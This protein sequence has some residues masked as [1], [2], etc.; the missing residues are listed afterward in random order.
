MT[1]SKFKPFGGLT[2]DKSQKL[3]LFGNEVKESKH[4]PIRY[5]VTPEIF[6]TSN[7]DLGAV[8][9]VSGIPFEVQGASELNHLQSALGFVIQSLGD[10]YAFYVTQ[11][12][13]QQPN[14]L[15]SN[16]PEGFSRDF[17]DAYNS[18]FQQ[19]QLYVNDIFITLLQKAG[20]TKVKKGLSFLEHLNARKDYET[21]NALNEAKLRKFKTALLNLSAA[22]KQYSP[23]ILGEK[24]YEDGLPEAE[25]LGFLSILVNGETREYTFPNQNIAEFVPEKRL[26]FGNNTLH[27]Q[28]ATQGDDL[29]GAMLSVKTYAPYT[30]PGLLDEMINMPFSYISTHSFLGIDKN[31]ALSLIDTQVRRLRS[32]NDAAKSQIFDLE[33]AKDDLASGNIT[34]GFHHNTILI[35]SRKINEL[36]EKVAKAIKIYQ[37]KRLVLIRETLYLEGA[38]WAQI[39]GNFRYIKRQAPISSNNFSCFC[40]LHNYYTGYINE[41]HLGSALMLAETS[42]KTPFYLNLHER[43]SGRKD[44]FPKGHTTLIGPSSAGKTVIITTIDAMMKKYGVR[45]FFFDRNYGC[46]IYVRAMGGVYNRLIPG[47]PTG[48]NPCQMSDTPQNKKFLRDFIEVLATS[49]TT[50]L[51]ASDLNQ[52]ADVV[53]RNYSLPEDK[54]NLSNIASF[55]SL[56]FGGLD[57]LSR[58]LNT[59]SRTGKQ[60]DRAYLFDNSTDNLKLDAKTMGFDMTHWLNDVGD[61]SEELL[62]I[63]MYL[64]YRID[65]CLD[66]SLTGLYLDEGWQFLNQPYWEKKLGE[67]LVT[68]R[69]RNAFVFFATQLPDKVAKSSLASALIQG[70]A[71]NIFL[72]NPKAEAQDYIEGFK[73]TNREYEIVKN[74]SI[75]SRYFLIKQG[76][77]AAVARINLN[78]LDKF[79]KVLSG[80][81]N[82]VA[83]C[84]QVIKEV[85]HDPKVWLP[86]FY[87]RVLS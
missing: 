69:K 85:G 11:Y 41:N 4:I 36:E 16:Y 25:V 72:P 35:L 52:I 55:F 8:I 1:S 45:S 17:S 26:F 34:Y 32:T 68:W 46:E 65:E 61:M 67:Y 9:K 56:D 27:I 30:S 3:A 57:A 59:P 28:G 63:S 13:H 51:T 81:D 87:Q 47:E 22:L 18:Q 15:V 74:N 54:R 83:I 24:Q 2:K 23:K 60:G 38:F 10:E 12:R 42:S 5:F 7:G 14:N 39:P 73:L 64:F 79:L 19:A 66:G 82:T 76:N 62:P 33:R 20:S 86:I 77:D 49:K 70:S 29:F 40:S 75:Q 78:G 71:T 58:Y 48:W 31:Q 37:D 6:T 43:A 44:D 53:E 80:N 50:P 21:S 84:N